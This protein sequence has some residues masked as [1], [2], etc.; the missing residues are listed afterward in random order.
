ML[1]LSLCF[2]Q[3]VSVCRLG[4]LTDAVYEE[5]GVKTIL[6]SSDT[7][8]YDGYKGYDVSKCLRN[9]RD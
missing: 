3:G 2:H 5:I 1:D 7:F 8:H 6:P 4:G 9:G